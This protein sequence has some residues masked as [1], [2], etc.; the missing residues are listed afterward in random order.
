MGA[1][2][3]ASHLQQRWL[4]YFDRDAL[5]QA[6]IHTVERLGT[7]MLNLELMPVSAAKKESFNL[8]GHA[9]AL[10]VKDPLMPSCFQNPETRQQLW[11]TMLLYDEAGRSVWADGDSVRG[12]SANTPNVIPTPSL[13]TQ[14]TR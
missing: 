13:A 5:N 10:L 7:S 1:A 12:S 9:I 4:D 8:G 14:Y 3:L 11:Q 2:T 6:Y